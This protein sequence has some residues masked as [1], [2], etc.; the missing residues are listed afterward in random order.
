ML[1][2]HLQYEPDWLGEFVDHCQGRLKY[3]KGVNCYPNIRG[4]RTI[5]T[6]H[7]SPSIS[8]KDA[9]ISDGTVPPLLVIQESS[10]A[11]LRICYQK[12][13]ILFL[14]FINFNI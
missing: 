6:T 7:V 2:P 3:I 14:Y 10:S 5:A 8:I 4:V 11:L 13:E 1:A 12:V 9:E